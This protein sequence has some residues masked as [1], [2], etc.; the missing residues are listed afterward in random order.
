MSYYKQQGVLHKVKVSAE[1]STAV[2]YLFII[3]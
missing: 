2:D 1:K 3:E